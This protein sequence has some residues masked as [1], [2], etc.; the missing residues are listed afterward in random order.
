MNPLFSII[1]VAYNSEKTIEQTILSVLNQTFSNYEYLIIDGGS[2]D[3]TL[4]IIKRYES[5]FC[6]K[7]KWIS[8]ADNGIYYAMNKG[9]SLAKGQYIGL[10]NS[11]DWYQPSA[12]EVVS[13]E[14]SE[15]IDIIYG[16]LNV[17]DDEKLLYVYA[18]HIDKLPQESLAHPSTFVSSDCYKKL[19]LYSTVYQSSS[20]YDFFL[21]AFTQKFIFKF[22]PSIL[23]NFRC[24]GMS[25]GSTGYFEALLIRYKHGYISKKSY[26]TAILSRKFKNFLS[27]IN[28]I[29]R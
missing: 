7:L 18:N 10:L 15:E 6:G 14:V 5:K 19:G 24:G 8:E 20:D 12:L 17:L 13:K 29:F 1:T 2:T 11:D 22:I 21:R 28:N 26:N 16:M 23:A 3:S 25:A 4:E 27:K 9:I